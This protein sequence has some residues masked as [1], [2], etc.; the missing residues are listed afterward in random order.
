MK[1]RDISN[2][3]MHLERVKSVLQKEETR[4]SKI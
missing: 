1:A 2:I 3:L 4:F